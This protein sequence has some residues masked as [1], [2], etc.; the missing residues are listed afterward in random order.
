MSGAYSVSKR[1]LSASKIIF[2]HRA[3]ISHRTIGNYEKNSPFVH[4]LVDLGTYFEEPI[5]ASSQLSERNKDLFGAWISKIREQI[6]QLVN[7]LRKDKSDPSSDKGDFAGAILFVMA[8][9]FSQGNTYIFG[10]LLVASFI[11]FA[12]KHL[13]NLVSLIASLIGYA[14]LVPI[15]FVIGSAFLG[16]I[17]AVLSVTQRRFQTMR[18]TLLS[19]ANLAGQLHERK[20]SA[21]RTLRKGKT[22]EFQK[23]M[24]GL[25][26][27]VD[28]ATTDIRTL[29]DLLSD[30]DFRELFDVPGYSA[31]VRAQVREPMEE[32]IRAVEESAMELKS[33]RE[34]LEEQINTTTDAQLRAPLHLQLERI[35]AQA[36]ELG[37]NQALISQKLELIRI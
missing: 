37:A 9:L 10:G 7:G 26:T 36:G 29:T 24:A 23:A 19:L 31:W 28:N 34:R 27:T 5:F 35:K 12:A 17:K 25:A 3:I 11:L 8:L 2:T 15:S 18:R 16:V 1:Y 20:A 30:E 33:G 14:I 6:K 4:G 21:I 32:L 13:W 22:S